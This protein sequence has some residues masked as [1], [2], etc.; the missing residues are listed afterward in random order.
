VRRYKGAS[1]SSFRDLYHE[2]LQAKH[3]MVSSNMRLVIAVAKRYG[4]M[5]VPLSDLVQE[6][7]IGLMRAA[8]KYDPKRG[9]KFSTYAS[10]WIQQAIYK[11]PL[12]RLCV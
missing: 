6:G 12:D 2:C 5:G 1:Q 9:F 10:W 7:S 11:V 3:L 8:E 4:R